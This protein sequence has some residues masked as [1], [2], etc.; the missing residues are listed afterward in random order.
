MQ[1]I[2]SL[3]FVTSFS[4]LLFLPLP[5]RCVALLRLPRVFCTRFSLVISFILSLPFI[6]LLLC[7][8]TSPA[9]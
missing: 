1:M 7:F 3:L 2:Y 4:L 8:G 5:L 9:C 6:I